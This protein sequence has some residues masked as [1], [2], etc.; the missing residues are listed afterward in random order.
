MIRASFVTLFGFCSQHLAQKGSENSQVGECSHMQGVDDSAQTPWHKR[1]CTWDPSGRSP[2][3][4]FLLAAHL[5]PA[6][7]FQELL[8]EAGVPKREGDEK[9]KES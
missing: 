7:S 5:N 9:R 6:G 8:E 1:F 3:R 2:V 4:L